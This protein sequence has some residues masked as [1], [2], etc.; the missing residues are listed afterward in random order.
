MGSS[1]QSPWAVDN[2]MRPGMEWNR[3]ITDTRSLTVCFMAHSD[4]E[5]PAGDEAKAR[6]IAAA[7]DLLVALQAVLAYCIDENQLTES[8]TVQTAQ[9]AI[10]K[11]T[12]QS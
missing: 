3:H 7:P 8:P 6:L 12:G 1:L 10:A 5:D 9:A 11:A 4:G 2:D